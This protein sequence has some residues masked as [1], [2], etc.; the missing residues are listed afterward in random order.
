MID[1]AILI[2]IARREFFKIIEVGKRR[3]RRRSIVIQ[4]VS[5]KIDRVNTESK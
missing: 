2:P 3:T 5:Q 1:V 4:L